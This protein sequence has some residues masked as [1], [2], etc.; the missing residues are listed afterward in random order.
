VLV[1]S[2]CGLS[3]EDCQ[4]V[5][6]KEVKRMKKALSKKALDQEAT[7]WDSLKKAA[8]ENPGKVCHK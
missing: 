3:I 5:A 1:L 6:G 2:I 7:F 4:S 8:K